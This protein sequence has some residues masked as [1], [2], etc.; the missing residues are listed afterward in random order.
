MAPRPGAES[1]ASSKR[2]ALIVDSCT[3]GYPGTTAAYQIN[4]RLP[5][6]ARAG[7]GAL[8]ITCAWQASAPVQIPVGAGN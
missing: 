7:V 2:E 6:N 5:A 1:F 4:L 3:G 8:Q